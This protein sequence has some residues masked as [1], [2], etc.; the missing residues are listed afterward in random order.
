MCYVACT[1]HCQTCDLN[2]PSCDPG[3]CEAGYHVDNNGKCSGEKYSDVRTLHRVV[4]SVITYVLVYNKICLKSVY[5]G[6]I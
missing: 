2:P 3:N 4:A 6:L 1:S 5:V